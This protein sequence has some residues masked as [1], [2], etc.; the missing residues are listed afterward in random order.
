MILEIIMSDMAFD[1]SKYPFCINKNW[2]IVD[3]GKWKWTR[4]TFS[5]ACCNSRDLPNGTLS[6]RMNFVY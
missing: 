2:T 4:P 3:D 1:V 5:K 6:M